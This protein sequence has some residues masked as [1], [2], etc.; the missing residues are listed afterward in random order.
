[1]CTY[2]SSNASVQVMRNNTSSKGE[3]NGRTGTRVRVMEIVSVDGGWDDFNV[4]FWLNIIFVLPFPASCSH[5]PFPLCHCYYLSVW[6]CWRSGG[7]DLTEGM[8]TLYWEMEGRRQ[9]KGGVGR[10][11]FPWKEPVC[12]ATVAIFM[13]LLNLQAVKGAADVTIWSMR[14]LRPSSVTKY[15]TT[16]IDRDHLEHA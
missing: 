11:V 12:R 1:M 7:S 4:Y 10:W 2:G 15:L 16:P 6:W 5:S 9:A 14:E 3:R 13:T 8:R